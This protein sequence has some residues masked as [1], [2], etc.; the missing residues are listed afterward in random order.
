MDDGTLL[1]VQKICSEMSRLEGLDVTSLCFSSVKKSIE[2][3]AEI[4]KKMGPYLI[5][6]IKK[7][8]SGNRF[9][10]K[11]ILN[12][13][14]IPRFFECPGESSN[15]PRSGNLDPVIGTAFCYGQT[16]RLP[17]GSKIFT[18]GLVNQ[19]GQIVGRLLPMQVGD[20]IEIFYAPMVSGGPSYQLLNP[21]F[22]MV[23]GGSAKEWN[24][25]VESKFGP[26]KPISMGSF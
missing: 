21:V 2:N 18:G 10:P 12:T 14:S 4:M 23:F 19:E 6:H 15:S 9:D 25:I 16:H 26:L 13:D 3:F 17:M 1:Q 7:S 20:E 22:F 8:F 11:K 24:A 5:E